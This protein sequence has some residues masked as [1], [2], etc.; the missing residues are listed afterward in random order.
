[1]IALFA[2]ALSLDWGTVWKLVRV[3]PMWPPFA[4]LRTVTGGLTTLEAGG[5]PMVANPFDPWQRP[6]NYPRVWLTAFGVL[7][8]NDGNVWIVGALFV[9]AYLVAASFLIL[10]ARDNVEAVALAAGALSYAALFAMERGNSDLLAFVLV[11]TAFSVPRFWVSAGLLAI[12]TW[13]KLFPLVA[14]VA[15]AVS[16]PRG[17]RAL[18]AAAVA[19]TA[20]LLF[21]FADDLIRIARA[22]PASP[23]WS[24]GVGSIFQL[25]SDGAGG[26]SKSEDAAFAAGAIAVGLVWA[27]GVWIGWSG[28]RRPTVDATVAQGRD[29]G[30]LLAFGSTYAATFFIG[31]NWVYRLIFLLPVLPF[32]CRMGR[33]SLA[34]RLTG[35]HLAALI[36][37]VMN[38]DA[39]GRLGLL[40]GHAAK[41]VLAY[42]LLYLSASIAQHRWR[43]LAAATGVRIRLSFWAYH[44]TS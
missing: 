35:Y 37:F 32:A 43:A 19:V 44:Q 5:D 42:L 12:A 21:A 8:V 14:F 27:S 30:W 18:G 25:V 4:D 13:V 39:A 26:W 40:V 3:P 38:V 31:S 11:L 7:G 28:Y 10:R 29:A 22:T 15:F 2:L 6:M 1:M 20:A 17:R 24:Y 33:A 23:I 9:T 34:G 16:Q 36:L 41:L